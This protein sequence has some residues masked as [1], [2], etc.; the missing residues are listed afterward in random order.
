M[1]ITIVKDIEIDVELSEFSDDD[2][3][4]EL[5][6]R[7]FW[8][9]DDIDLKSILDALKLNQEDKALQLMRTFLS[10]KYGVVL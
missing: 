4:A 7:D 2:L 8:I 9:E 5:K 10:N 1:S 3:I 6:E